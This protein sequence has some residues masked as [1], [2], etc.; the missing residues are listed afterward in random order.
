MD[1]YPRWALLLGGLA[2]AASAWGQPPIEL[3]LASC[4]AGSPP[5]RVPAASE[6]A[7]LDD[8][9]RRRFDDAARARYPVVQRSGLA[10]TR[11]LILRRHGQWQYLTLAPGGPAGS[12]VS[13]VFAADRFDF[14]PAWLGKYRPQAAVLGD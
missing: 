14:T 1:S 12:C 13:A 5:L 7:E 11:I 2:A 6:R 4:V 3:E 8:A 10:S 9:D